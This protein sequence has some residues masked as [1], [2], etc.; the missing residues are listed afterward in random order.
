MPTTSRTRLVYLLLF[1]SGAAALVYQSL[2]TRQLSLIMGSTTYA[3]GTVLAA[4]MA[5]LGAGAALLGQRAD[6]SARP[7]VLYAALEVGI[8]VAGLASPFVLAQGN[9]LYAACYGLLRDLPA[10]LT[11]TRFAIGFVLVAIPAALMGG[12]LPVAVRVLV[13]R[14]DGL[15][16]VVGH[17]YACNTFGAAVGAL[18]LPFVL[19]PALG[20][21]ATLFAC[22][23]TNLALGA[24][25]W[26]AGRGDAPP[27]A[28]P[29]GRRRAPGSPRPLP[30]GLLPAFFVSGF[31][32]LGLEVAWNR[33]FGTYFG[34]SIYS[35][36]VILALYLVGIVAGSELST[37]LLRRGRDPVQVFATALLLLVVDLALTIPLM[38]GILYAHLAVYD[39]VG[40]G[41]GAYQLATVAAA[42]LVVLP[43]TVLFGIS[44]P[45]VAAAAGGKDDEVGSTLGRVYLVNTAGTAVGVIVTSFALVAWLGVRGTLDMLVLLA[46][47][48][49]VLV[50]G[51]ERRGLAAL[52][53]GVALLPLVA[54][55]WDLR[56]MHTALAQDPPTV[57]GIWRNGGLPAR[58]QSEHVIEMRD[59]VDVT[60]AVIQVGREKS[61]FVNGKPD[62]SDALIDRFT[63]TMLGHL[64]MLLHPAPRDV[65]VIGM[66]S[67]ATLGATT[68]YPVTAI[69]LVEVSPEVLALGDAHFRA[70]NHDALHDPRVAVHIEDGRNFVAFDRTRTYDVII[71]EPSNPWMTGV[72]NLF[73]DEFFRQVRARLKDDGILSQWF[74]YYSMELD[75]V[76]SLVATVEHHFPYV[77]AF[78]FHRPDHLGDLFLVASGVPFDFSRV[79]GAFS[80][81]GAAGADLRD[82]GRANPAEL[83]GGLVLSPE[84]VDRFIGGV[85]LNSDDRPRI[86]LHAPRALFD[87][88]TAPGNL[89]ALLL[90]SDGARIPTPAP[91]DLGATAYRVRGFEV[92]PPSGFRLTFNGLR[93][94]LKGESPQDAAPPRDLLQQLTFTDAQNGR[95]EV[96]NARGDVDAAAALRLASI[97]GAGAPAPTGTGEVA[98]HSAS[99]YA[100]AGGTT[101]LVWSCPRAGTSHAL[102]VTA[103]GTP[104][105]ATDVAAGVRCHA[106]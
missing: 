81:Q 105:T 20:M 97:A 5:G 72:A 7:L 36:A 14:A 30:S 32:A 98:G 37:V 57:V 25:A 15:G 54:P 83:L 70:I 31:V 13:R 55:A 26:I 1:V 56:L 47:G 2:W 65:L 82:V 63:Q 77:Y 95:I 11:L 73:T 90:A 10:A 48:A 58:I 52:A 22:G 21:R 101:A 27:A 39:L 59:G 103:G 74:H 42:L 92:V 24:A 67:G 44:F 75:E 62:A 41:F 38:D 8:G 85:G 102:A 12:T 16:R 43:P 99:A 40:V 88:D 69:D 33:F 89:R 100:V 94:G 29:A 51:S 17:L 104:L 18:A 80:G 49:F 64:P 79:T 28:A 86:E 45:A 19:L 35:Y 93:V 3:I 4:F 91:G 50:A 71:S 46:A 6:R 23:V 96:V 60:A 78:A 76:R 106:D 87:D 34:S 68:R 61:L 53:A 9:V 66:G 84:V